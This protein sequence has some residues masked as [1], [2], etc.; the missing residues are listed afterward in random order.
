MFSKPQPRLFDVNKKPSQ[1]KRR[2]KITLVF[3]E[4][5]RREFLGGF[6][7]RKLERKRK[8][9][10]Q[11][12]QQLKEER[13]KIKQEVRERYKKSLSQQNIP[14]IEELL[15]R[16]EYKLQDHTV[17]IL[18]L[19]IA[20]LKEGSAWIG[21]NKIAEEKEEE[22]EN[23]ESEHSNDDKD[24]IVGMSLQKKQIVAKDIAPDSKSNHQEIKSSKELKREM[25]KIALKQ[26]KKSK[27]FQQKQRLEQQKNKKRSKQK[28]HKA[29]K[30]AH[31]SGKRNK[32][33]P[34]H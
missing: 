6:R 17:S 5:K 18:E 27:A 3:D 12:Q 16:Q 21:Q 25:R 24:E 30:L 8:A 34:A 19:N 7:K 20:D 13:K 22:Q 28:L 1:P 15:S 11:L 9:Q 26:V 23:D 4:E 32:K 29:Q 33:K 2:K 14:E 31:K 10:E